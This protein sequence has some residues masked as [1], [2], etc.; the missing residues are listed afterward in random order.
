MSRPIAVLPKQAAAHRGNPPSVRKPEEVGCF[1]IDENG[2]ETYGAE[3]KQHLRAYS[4][5][6]LP[7]D[8]NERMST[9]KPRTTAVYPLFPILRG[10]QHENV[11]LHADILSFRN[12]F[13]KIMGTPYNRSE[14]WQVGIQYTTTMDQQPLIL[15]HILPPTPGGPHIRVDTDDFAQRA[16]YWGYRFEAVCTNSTEEDVDA[17][18]EYCAIV[19]TAVGNHRLLLGAE[20]DCYRRDPRAPADAPPSLNEYVEL[21][22]TKEILEEKHNISF[23]KY[24][25]LKYWIQCFLVGVQEVIVGYRDQAGN[26]KKIEHL[27]VKDIPR[28]ASPGEK[29]M[30]D[31]GRCLSF[32]DQ[33]L[34]MVRR[35]VRTPDKAYVLSFQPP[36]AQVELRED[37]A[38]GPVLH[39]AP[40]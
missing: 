9:F 22:T 14:P 28:R 29:P 23:A 17:N 30:W 3:A 16:S 24:K 27:K 31:Y 35:H 25:L 13:N 19:R 5:P 12:N 1:H 2:K 37:S 33:V 11:P 8:L 10:L 18:V 40:V 4:T 20:M 6:R 32:T 7:V 38:A 21:K 36:F 15:F 26:L 34:S 39:T